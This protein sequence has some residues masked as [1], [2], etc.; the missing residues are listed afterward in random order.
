MTVAGTRESVQDLL[1]RL[2]RGRHNLKPLQDLFWTELNYDRVNDALPHDSWPE[3][4]RYALAD[5][6]ILFP[7]GGADDEFHVISKNGEDETVRV[8]C[9]EALV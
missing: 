9:S 2:G 6:P 1:Q 5:D 7:S 4:T 3:Y 8:I